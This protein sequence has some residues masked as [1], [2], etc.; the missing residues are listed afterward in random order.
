MV[1]SSRSGVTRERRLGPAHSA[2]YTAAISAVTACLK[3]AEHKVPPPYPRCAPWYL[4]N[5]R[6]LGGQWCRSAS[7]YLYCCTICRAGAGASGAVREAAPGRGAAALPRAAGVI[8]RPPSAS[9]TGSLLLL[10]TKYHFF[11]WCSNCC[12]WTAP[13]RRKP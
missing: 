8:G 12:M 2:V 11:V 10:Y 6:V 9:A 4:G 13:R 7:I 5:V 1:S 3:V